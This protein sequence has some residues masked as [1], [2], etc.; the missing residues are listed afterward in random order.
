MGIVI[1]EKKGAMIFIWEIVIGAE[2][3]MNGLGPES[4]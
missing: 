4:L 3:V 1:L 2:K